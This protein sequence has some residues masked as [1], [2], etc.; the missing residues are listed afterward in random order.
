MSKPL[1]SGLRRAASDI[2][3]SRRIPDILSINDG[4]G[5]KSGICQ[6][7]QRG[8]RDG[9]KLMA[10]PIVIPAEA[11]IQAGRPEE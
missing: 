11:G 4:G 8:C 10:I 1:D 5:L 3:S 2:L 9:D 6:A 7:W